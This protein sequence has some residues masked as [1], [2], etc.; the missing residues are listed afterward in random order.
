MYEAMMTCAVAGGSR[1]R[2]EMRSKPMLWLLVL[3]A[4]LLLP[5]LWVAGAV[6]G[7]PYKHWSV[8]RWDST[9]LAPDPATTPEPVVQVYA[10][11]TWGWKGIFAVHSWIIL[12]RRG[13][14]RY[15][16]YEVVGWGVGRGAPA[17]RRNM[18][19]PDGFWAGNRPRLLLERRGPGV[20]L[21][22]D[23][24]EAAIASY[25]YRQEYRTWPGPN[26]NTFIAH[27]ARSVPALGLELP[28]M[29]IGKDY[30]NNGSLLATT[31]SGTGLQFSLFGL[32]GI[33]IARA[34]GLEINLLG[35]TIGID[36]LGLAIK[37]PG[38]GRLGL[39]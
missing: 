20:E 22:I 35:L 37:L 19:E 3:V 31:P 29:A 4:I 21:L 11:R 2:G 16:R 36:P 23:Q 28:P 7:G 24:I 32:F 5:H 27:I 17:I 12:K 33:A 26:S 15:D 14:P 1:R 13:A 6:H 34:E 18:R 30:L 9:G 8:A 38:I 25:P 10:A 39:T